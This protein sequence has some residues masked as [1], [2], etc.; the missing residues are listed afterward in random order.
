MQHTYAMHRTSILLDERAR[1]AAKELAASYG[2]STSEAI[3]RAV[4]AQRDAAIGVSDDVRR[5]RVEALER[6]FTL[7]EGHD[8]AA[9]VAEIKRQ[10]EAG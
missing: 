7:F 3:R 2:C 5:D 6:L 4:V 8:P 10:D 1:R 9:E